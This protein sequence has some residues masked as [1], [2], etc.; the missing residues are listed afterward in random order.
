MIVTIGTTPFIM[1][2][3]VV[4]DGRRFKE[5]ETDPLTGNLIGVD[6]DVILVVYR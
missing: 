5:V 2:R 1:A 3:S 4:K 6:N